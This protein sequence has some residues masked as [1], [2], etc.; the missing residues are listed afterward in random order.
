M[1]RTAE[2]ETL[3]QLAGDPQTWVSWLA[4]LQRAVADGELELLEELVEVLAR[5]RPTYLDVA[6]QALVLVPGDAAAVRAVATLRRHDKLGSPTRTGQHPDAGAR[7]RAGALASRHGPATLAHAIDTLGLPDDLLSLM[8][9]WAQELVIRGAALAGPAIDALARALVACDHPLGS[10]PMHRL[11]LEVGSEAVAATY[12]VGSMSCWGWSAPT[13]PTIAPASTLPEVVA[14]GQPDEGRR[15]ASVFSSHCA[16]SNGRVKARMFRFDR[17][18][19]GPCPALL[20]ALP[21]GVLAGATRVD[22]RPLSAEQ[23][24]TL[25]L[26]FAAN[27]G[28]YNVGIS[29][30]YGR[31]HAWR[32]LGGLVDAPADAPLEAIEAEARAVE[33]IGGFA[34]FASDSR[35]FNH[36]VTDLGLAT[37]R[38]DGRSL[39][40]LAGTDTD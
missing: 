7:L 28:D 40:V 31:L 19:Q 18:V 15:I 5:Q 25:L 16:V 8:A 26:A 24:F 22:V 32:S 27:G 14:I 23:V 2:A 39:A 21:L 10:L 37:V 17:A 29:G 1:S 11:A 3:A 30:A 6:L 20:R 33:R 36:V 34:H 9:C 38:V 4:R 13:G 12:R 35:W